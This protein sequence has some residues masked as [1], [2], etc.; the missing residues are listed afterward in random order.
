VRVVLWDTRKLDAA[1]D[2]AGGF[3][4]G[5]YHGAGGVAGQVVRYW[6]KRDRRPVAMNFAYLAAVFKALGHQVEYSEDW[7]PQRAD[8]YVF[9]PS[10]ITLDLERKAMSLAA[11]ENRGCRILVVGL[12]A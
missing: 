8:L 12:V 6:Y 11:R 2:F 1:K 10:L 4:V 5:Q 7:V 3:G 9:N